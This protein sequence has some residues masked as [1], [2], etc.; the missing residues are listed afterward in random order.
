MRNNRLKERKSNDDYL[1]ECQFEETPMLA[2][3]RASERAK[4]VDDEDE[5]GEEEKR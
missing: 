4:D 3:R 2:G 5:E 1:R